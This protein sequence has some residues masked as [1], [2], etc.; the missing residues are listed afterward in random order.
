[1]KNLN[2]MLKK[3]GYIDVFTYKNELFYLS[4][5]ETIL[6][7]SSLFF[8]DSGYRLND[9]YIFA[10]SAPLYEIKGIVL[11]N[12]NEY[13]EIMHSILASKFKIVLED[14]SNNVVIRRQYGM[15]KILKEEFDFK[16][17]IL[18][19]GFPNFPTCPYGH[20]FKM[21]GY[22][23]QTKTYVR[24]APA[25]LKEHSLQTIEYKE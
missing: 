9:V 7:A 24:L 21:L 11:L 23:M 8:I 20:S 25:I 4:N 14:E 1:M 5:S 6:C 16:R 17:Y 3:L 13:K 2:D 15:R 22:D 18:R 19:K 12:K 10:L